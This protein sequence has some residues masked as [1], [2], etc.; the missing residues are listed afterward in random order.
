MKLDAQNILKLV[1]QGEG[2]SLEFKTCRTALN[3]DVYESVCAF[4]NRYGGTVLLG[5]RD[6]GEVQGVAPDAV[7]SIRKDFVNAINNPQKITPTTYRLMKFR[8]KEISFCASTTAMKTA[9]FSEN[10][11]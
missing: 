3:R 4:L 9:T 7:E 11:V 6:S 5:V 2:L 10:K 1:E 8:E